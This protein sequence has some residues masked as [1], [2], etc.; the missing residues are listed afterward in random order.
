MRTLALASLA[1][2]ASCSSNPAVPAGNADLSTTPVDATPPPDGTPLAD[3]ATPDL[4]VAADLTPA[5]D[6]AGPVGQECGGFVGKPCPAPLFCDFPMNCGAADE[7]GTCH[8]KPMGCPKYYDPVC[9][10]DGKVYGN[11]CERQ[12]AGASLLQWGLCGC[13]P[14]CAPGNYCAQCKNVLVCLAKGTAC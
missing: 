3:L 13:S 10:C 2:L 8:E 14:R 5:P 12:M 1:L 6:L 11:D 7:P 9:G 4:V